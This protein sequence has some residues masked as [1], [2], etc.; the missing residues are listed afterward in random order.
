MEEEDE[1]TSLP[2]VAG[3]VGMVDDACTMAHLRNSCHQA[4]NPYVD[5]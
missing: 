1:D 4:S 2:A 3:N 5:E